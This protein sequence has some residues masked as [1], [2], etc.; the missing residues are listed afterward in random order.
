MEDELR[1]L[2]LDSSRRDSGTH[3]QPTFILKRPINLNVYGIV[4]AH[5]RLK[6]RLIQCT[7]PYSFYTIPAGFNNFKID[8]N[9]LTIEP[10]DY[11]IFQLTRAVEDVVLDADLGFTIEVLYNRISNKVTIF[12]TSLTSIDI[13]FDSST[14]HQQLGFSNN[15]FSVSIL[16]SLTSDLV[17]NVAPLSSIYVR[18]IGLAQTNSEESGRESGFSDILA[19]VPIDTQPGSFIEY[20]PSNPAIINILAENIDNLT[21]S[22][23][24]KD[25]NNIIFLNGLD[26]TCTIEI[27]IDIGE[28][29]DFVEIERQRQRQRLAIREKT[30]N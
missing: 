27:R 28:P 15:V 18:A 17:V 7:I 5:S 14:F 10:G 4:G 23:T 16:E 8:G 24:T 12:T 25:P 26:W 21:L 6:L 1:Y 19:K 20:E 30:A 11:N 22:L 29:L 2:Q 9:T 13:V 3:E